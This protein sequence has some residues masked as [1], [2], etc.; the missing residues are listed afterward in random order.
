MINDI[1]NHH[2]HS[3]IDMY[4]EDTTLA[5]ANKCVKTI[6]SKLNEDAFTMFINISNYSTLTIGGF[7]N[8]RRPCKTLELFKI[9]C[10]FL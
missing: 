10:N 2:K 1:V 8:N 7:L 4:V 6:E 5:V 3:E 9:N